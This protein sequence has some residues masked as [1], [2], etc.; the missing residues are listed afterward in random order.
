M[1][2]PLKPLSATSAFL[3]PRNAWSLFNAFIKA[4]KGNPI[5]LQRHTEALHYLLDTHVGLKRP[6]LTDP[7]KRSVQRE[8]RAVE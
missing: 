1:T 3:A 4:S 8:R 2:T 5:E 6:S 7:H